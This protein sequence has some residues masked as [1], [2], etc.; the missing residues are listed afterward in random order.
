VTHQWLRVSPGT[1][2]LGGVVAGGQRL[3][4]GL[5]DAVLAPSEGSLLGAKRGR[6]WMRFDRPDVEGAET[7]FE[8]HLRS[9]ARSKLNPGNYAPR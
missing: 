2:P 9:H 5:R 1:W 6:T 4:S 7:H 3:T 8:V